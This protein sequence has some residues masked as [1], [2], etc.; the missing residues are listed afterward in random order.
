MVSRW[1]ILDMG[2]NTLLLLLATWENEHNKLRII[3]DEHFIARLGAA[4]PEKGTIGD[5]ELRR[6]TQ[7][8]LF[9]NELCRC[10][11]VQKIWAIGTA[12]FRKAKNANEVIASLSQCFMCNFEATILSPEQEA[13]LSFWGAELPKQS[14]QLVAVIDIGGGST[15]LTVGVQWEVLQSFSLPLGALWLWERAQHH[16]WGLERI[17]SFVKEMV[18]D[19][20]PSLRSPACER[21]YVLAGTPVTLAGILSGIPYQEWWRTHGSVI[22]RDDLTSL[23]PWLWNRREHLRDLPTVHPDRADILPAGAVIL[24]ALLEHLCLPSVSVSVYG[25]RYGALCALLHR[26]GLLDLS[27]DFVVEDYRLTL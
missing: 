4:V 14:K 16:G 7:V 8:A 23:L 6:A 10:H 19:T 21:A 5:R 1:G 27:R 2:S 13:L 11:A 20:L 12:V 22:S 15:E 25:L 9:Y 18:S 17:R 26:E 24:D 3:A